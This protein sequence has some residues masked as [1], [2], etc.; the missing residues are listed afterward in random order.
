MT[1]LS[2]TFLCLSTESLGDLKTNKSNSPFTTHSSDRALLKSSLNNTV[3]FWL[4]IH[5]RGRKDDF[6][7]PSV[8]WFFGILKLF[9][10][11]NRLSCSFL[12]N[13]QC[14]WNQYN[15]H[16]LR[17]TLWL[18][19]IKGWFNYVLIWLTCFWERYPWEKCDPCCK[20]HVG[21][22]AMLLLLILLVHLPARF[23]SW[24]RSVIFLQDSLQKRGEPPMWQLSFFSFNWHER[25]RPE[26]PI[27]PCLQTKT[28]IT[29]PLHLC[30]EKQHSY[31]LCSQL[32]SLIL[33]VW[34]RPP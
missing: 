10:L 2:H 33:R 13:T 5:R 30:Q 6:T 17:H 11:M 21:T 3:Y 19:E 22:F 26:V 23:L 8:K 7:Y 34:L 31:Q 15:W 25:G 9:L 24:D 12:R 14:I 1:V 29:N 16:W 32:R 18:Q 28:T 20:W 27:R 4:L